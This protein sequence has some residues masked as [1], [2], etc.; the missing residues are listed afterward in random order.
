LKII[1][2]L[3]QI[4][5]NEETIKYIETVWDI[6]ATEFEVA[7]PFLSPTNRMKREEISFH[8]DVKLLGYLCLLI[9]DLKGDI[10]EIGIWKGKTLA[11][12]NKVSNSSRNVVGID[13][14]LL[15]NQKQELLFYKEKVFPD[16]LIFQGFSEDLVAEVREITSAIALLHIDGGHDKRNVFLDFLLY[17]P[18]VVSGGFIV[19]DDY[20]DNDHSPQVGPAVDLLRVGGFFNEYTIIGSVDNF[21]NSYVLRKN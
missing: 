21:R 15:F 11:F 18:L 1:D 20:H 3:K 8:Q 5:T 7:R 17:S 10:I 13:P 14:C 9:D 12:M 19:F 2:T 6:T 4:T 16:C